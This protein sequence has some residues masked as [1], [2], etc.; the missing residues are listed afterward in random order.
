MIEVF[1]LGVVFQEDLYRHS[2]EAA[3][4]FYVDAVLQQLRGH[5]APE[6]VSAGSAGES[7]SGQAEEALYSV[8]EGG[9]AE[10]CIG[11]DADDEA[12]GFADE[13]L[14]CGRE[15]DEAFGA[16]GFEVFDYGSFGRANGGLAQQYG[17]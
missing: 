11:V 3:D 9:R 1:G 8:G 10:G 15:G 13:F 5:A 7:D 2:T 17:V 12:G 14:K 6:G 16:V 4:S